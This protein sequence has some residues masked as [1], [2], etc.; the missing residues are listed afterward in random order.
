MKPTCVGPFVNFKV[1]HSRKDFAAF[2]GVRSL[3]R[4]VP[5]NIV[6]VTMRMD[7]G[8]VVLHN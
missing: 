4:V 8:S 2:T 7:S 1:F 3:P 5:A 6:L